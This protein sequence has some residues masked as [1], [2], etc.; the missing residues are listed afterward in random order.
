MQKQL[1]TKW[2]ILRKSAPF[3]RKIGGAWD[4]FL[5]KLLFSTLFAYI[6]VYPSQDY[7]LL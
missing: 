3:Q 2:K 7:E 4:I 6:L 5:R 1:K